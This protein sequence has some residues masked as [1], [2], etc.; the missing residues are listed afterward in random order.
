V[1]E[2]IDRA[3]DAAAKCDVLLTLGTT[4]AVYP[5]AAMP[6]VALEAGA[7]LVV[8]NAEDTAYDAFAHAR[9]HE[10]LG[11]VLPALVARI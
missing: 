4:L 11:V 10:Q 5:V 3:I 6:Q 7:R 9:F 1:P 8:M 2:V